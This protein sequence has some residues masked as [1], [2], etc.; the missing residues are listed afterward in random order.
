M[1][2]M[3]VVKLASFSEVLNFVFKLNCFLGALVVWNTTWECRWREWLGVR[4]PRFV[5]ITVPC[6]L[7]WLNAI[8]DSDKWRA[9]SSDRKILCSLFVV[10]FF[11]K[12]RR[13][14][15]HHFFFL[16]YYRF[17]IYLFIPEF[18]DAQCRLLVFLYCGNDTFF[19]L[20][21]SERLRELNL[22]LCVVFNA[23]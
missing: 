23:G 3:V 17:D 18:C 10:V 14:V 5:L 4:W 19:S 15:E 21:F 22:L 8:K 20:V 16:L 13:K 2:S 1:Q 7:S 12:K 9:G 11:F 6:L